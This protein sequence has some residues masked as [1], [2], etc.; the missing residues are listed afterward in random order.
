MAW[1]ALAIAIAH[2]D[3]AFHPVNPRRRRN[4]KST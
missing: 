2:E 4:A 1:I 3:L